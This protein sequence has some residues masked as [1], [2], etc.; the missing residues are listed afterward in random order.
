MPRR[1]PL[2]VRACLLGAMVA[3]ALLSVSS[4]AILAT[5]AVDDGIEQFAERDL[6]FAAGEAADTAAAV[7]LEAGS[8]SRSSVGAL[9][10]VA[11]TRGAAVAIVDLAG[12]PVPGSPA[13]P[14]SGGARTPVV[15][16]GARVG[17]VIATHL[18][19]GA[20]DG[21]AERVD[22]ELDRHVDR[23]LESAGALA[24]VLGLGFALVLSLWMARPLERLTRVARR[25][26]AG[27]IEAR[28][29][30][31]GGGRELA[32]LARTMDRL[33]ASLRRQEERRRATAADVTHELRRALVGVVGRIELL[34]DGHAYDTA[35]TLERMAGDARRMHRLVDDVD[36]L[37]EAQRPALMVDTRRVDLGA[38]AGAA[39]ERAED[40]CRLRGIALR[41]AIEPVTVEGDPV[42]LGQVVDNLISNALR[43]TDEGGRVALSV[44][45]HG[46]EAVI[47]VSDTGIGI[48][49]AHLRS[50]FDRF[51]RAPGAS[52]RA[53]SGSG[54]GLAVVS[55]I[56]MAHGGR[57]EVASREGRGSTF[58]VLLP[59][60]APQ[61]LGAP[62]DVPAAPELPAAAPRTVAA[63]DAAAGTV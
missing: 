30:G 60:A 7:Y 35:V 31:S 13:A 37:V 40:A 34:Q 36:L 32:E 39:A 45:V 63:R 12:R 2:G 25:M 33:A 22:H 17:T 55:E 61:P 44:V 50:V 42:R 5:R 52:D 43:Y 3:L 14:P 21:V 9:R 53:P 56:V 15:V 54:V 28:A 46:A 19:D 62:A 26:E 59:L 11:R 27:N 4:T 41:T 57:V 49:P 1:R 48:A 24:A 47:E 58:S 38:I 23:L 29:T 10:A 20:I 51:W 6:G 16:G 18:P 8:W